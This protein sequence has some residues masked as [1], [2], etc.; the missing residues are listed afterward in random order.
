MNRDNCA[1][2][3]IVG[4]GGTG[5]AAAATAAKEGLKVIL[6]EKR[7]ATGGNSACA[8]GIFAADSPAQRRNMIQ[9]RGDDL[10]KF[11]MDYTHW[12][13]N[14]RIIRAFIDKSGE[15]IG[16]LEHMGLRFDWIPPYYNGQPFQVWHCLE[17]GTGTH[18]TR[19]LRAECEKNGVDIRTGISGNKILI[20]GGKVCGL[21][22]I[23]ETGE[24][25]I[26]SVPNVVIATGGFAGNK[27]MLLRY[28]PDYFE[29]MTCYAGANAGDGL[30]MALDAGCDTEGLGLLFLNGPRFPGNLLLNAVC[31]EP[32]TMWVNKKGLRYFDESST[33]RFERANAVNRQPNHLSFTMFDSDI[34]QYL[35]EEGLQKGIGLII[36]QATK[37]EDIDVLLTEE[38]AKGNVYIADSIEELAIKAGIPAKEL[39]KN[40]DEYNHCCA[41]GHDP[42]FA[43]EREYLRPIMKAPFY[44]IRCESSFLSTIGGIRINEKMEVLDKEGEVINGLYAGGVDVGGWEIDSYNCALSGSCVGFA[45]NSGRIA[46]ENIALRMN[47]Q[48]SS[49]GQ[50]MERKNL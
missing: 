8:E 35:K 45:L 7:K 10:F 44:M 34:R 39:V 9:A 36:R 49:L 24:E 43:K 14:P 48:L 31:Q 40:V 41:T 15:T 16:W 47:N 13:A 17:G 2:V 11:A 6:L 1:D 4:G 28:C 50:V 27:K 29:G 3:V 22:A 25:V 18:I 12:R 42:I 26:F 20:D 32:G 30:E 23:R 46:G 21:R 37:L 33:F 38:E 19:V 5:L